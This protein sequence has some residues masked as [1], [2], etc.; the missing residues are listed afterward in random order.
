VS[1]INPAAIKAYAQSHLS[2]TK[3]DRVG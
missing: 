1:V 3:T 2:R